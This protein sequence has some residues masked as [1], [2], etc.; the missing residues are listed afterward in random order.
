MTPIPFHHAAHR[1]HQHHGSYG[2]CEQG[3]GFGPS[4]PVEFIGIWNGPNPGPN[5]AELGQNFPLAMPAAP[6]LYAQDSQADGPELWVNQANASKNCKSKCCSTQ[7][8]PSRGPVFVKGITECAKTDGECEK[9]KQGPLRPFT[10]K[11]AGA[12]GK[13]ISRSFR[14]GGHS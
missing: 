8:E 4:P 7:Q 14:W 13:H 11:R 12:D 1:M 2:Q 9:E 10:G 3:Q 6:G 5:P